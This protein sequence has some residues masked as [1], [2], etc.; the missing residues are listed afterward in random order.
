MDVSIYFEEPFFAQSSTDCGGVGGTTLF[1][2]G[3]HAI[4]EIAALQFAQSERYGPTRSS[5]R[6]RNTSDEAH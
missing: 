2:Q 1:S 5:D 6:R 3:K 4:T